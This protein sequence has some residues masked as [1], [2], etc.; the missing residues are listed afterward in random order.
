MIR[1]PFQ[2]LNTVVTEPHYFFHF[3]VF[4]SY[5]PKGV[6][7]FEYDLFVTHPGRF[8]GGVASIQCM[9]AP[10]FISHSEGIMVNVSDQ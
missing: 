1:N 8:S 3:L 4:F 6:H 10:E 2:W 5:L 9:Y 7:I